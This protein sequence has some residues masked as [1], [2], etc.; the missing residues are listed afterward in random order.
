MRSSDRRPVEWTGSPF[1]PLAEETPQDEPS[2]LTD[3]DEVI[4][5]RVKGAW[6]VRGDLKVDALIDQAD[7]FSVGSILA[8]A[9]RP[10]T[11]E[12]SRKIKGGLAIKL[13]I[14]A[15]RSDAEA[16]R[17][18]VF[19]VP[20]ELLA[21]LPHGRYYYF[22]IIDMV[23]LDEAG[24]ELGCVKEIIETGVNDVYVI[25]RPEQPDLLIPALEDVVLSVSVSEKHM[26]VRVPEGLA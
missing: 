5:G 12:Q 6:G 7:R 1:L 15:S 19:T 13:D 24:D 11:V 20:R 3:G 21:P 23:V 2:S 4:V 9:G 22:D 16:A 8:L 26:T 18:Q 17:G 25:E 14:V 10:A